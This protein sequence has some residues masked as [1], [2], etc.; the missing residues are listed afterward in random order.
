MTQEYLNKLGKK[1]GLKK[2]VDRRLFAHL[3]RVAPLMGALKFESLSHDRHRA[4]LE[5]SKGTFTSE[6]GVSLAR[7]S[8]N[9]MKKAY[10]AGV[11]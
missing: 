8:Y 7:A 9:S 1:A 2:E 5:T 3:S 6:S 10:K 11:R 4:T